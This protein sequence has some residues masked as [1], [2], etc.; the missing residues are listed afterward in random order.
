MITF[1]SIPRGGD[2]HIEILKKAVRSWRKAAPKSQVI[3]FGDDP[4]VPETAKLLRTQ[5]VAEVS[6][7]EYGTPLIDGVWRQATELAQN[8]WLMEISGDIL[9]EDTNLQ[10]VIAAVSGY[11]KPFIIGQRWDSYANS[12]G[13][14][15]HAPCGVDYFLFKRGT[16]GEIPPFAVGRNVYDNWL[17]WAALYRW[18]MHV[19]DGTKVIKTIHHYHSFSN[20]A[21][22]KTNAVF[23]AERQ[24]NEQLARDTGC[25]RWSG[26][27]E[28][29]FTIMTNY[30][31]FGIEGRG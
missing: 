9:L 20:N 30:K 3:L 11:A 6:R 21:D 10:D 16:V 2:E 12:T 5:H 26:V 1:F 13:L 31:V 19:F 8:D 14:T 27:D 7:N 25:N 24:Q 4:G 28:A 18:G 17:V 23:M 29:Q 15:L 22:T